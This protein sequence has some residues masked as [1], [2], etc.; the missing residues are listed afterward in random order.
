MVDNYHRVA[1]QAIAWYRFSSIT[2][3]ID[4]LQTMTGTKSSSSAN[5]QVTAHHLADQN[6]PAESMQHSSCS[7]GQP[8]ARLA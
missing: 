2:E 4:L 6:L 8:G 7:S 3:F 1:N 5:W